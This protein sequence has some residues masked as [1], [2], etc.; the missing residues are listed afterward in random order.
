LSAELL[1]AYNTA[2]EAASVSAKAYKD[3]GTS[4]DCENLKA[5]MDNDQAVLVAAKSASDASAAYFAKNYP[6]K[7]GATAGI[8]VGC[9]AATLCIGYG[10]YTFHS[11]KKEA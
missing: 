6:V 11:E 2:T 1:A 3:C 5:E 8:I 7:T 9:I 4:G 10:A